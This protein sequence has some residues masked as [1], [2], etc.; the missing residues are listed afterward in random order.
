MIYSLP[1]VVFNSRM[2]SKLYELVGRLLWTT[3]SS[4]FFMWSPSSFKKWNRNVQLTIGSH[5][6][7]HIHIGILSVTMVTIGKYPFGDIMG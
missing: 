2:D 4:L 3:N 1:L 7:N 5:D 6:Y